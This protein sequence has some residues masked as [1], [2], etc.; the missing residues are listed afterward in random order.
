MSKNN[1]NV[2]YAFCKSY[3]LLERFELYFRICC[4]ISLHL[5]NRLFCVHLQPKICRVCI[6]LIQTISRMHACINL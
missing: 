2:V 3:S 4:I 5:F 6:N 1:Y